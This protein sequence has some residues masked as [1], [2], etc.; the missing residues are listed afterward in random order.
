MVLGGV[1]I[2]LTG[3]LAA[4]LIA[5]LLVTLSGGALGFLASAG[6]A[7]VIGTLFG[8]AGGGLTGYRYFV[9]CLFVCF[10]SLG[11]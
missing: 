4:P 5:P 10:F 11:V 3:G 2:G 7:V 1:A 8:I 6:G 9:I